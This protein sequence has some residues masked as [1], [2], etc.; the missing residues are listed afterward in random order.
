MTR[1]FRGIDFAN[2]QENR[3]TCFLMVEKGLVTPVLTEPTSVVEMSAVDCPFGTTVGFMELLMGSVRKVEPSGGYKAR[4]TEKWLRT[5]L[6]EF[7][8]NKFWRGLAHPRRPQHYVNKP[9]HVKSTLELQI[10]PALI[11][12]FYGDAGAT[13]DSQTL[14]QLREAR[15]GRGGIVEAHPRAFLYSAI[16]RIYREQPTNEVWKTV[17]GDVATYKDHQKVS[18]TAQRRRVY[19]F[20]QL[21]SSDWLWNDLHLSDAPELLFSTDHHFDAFLAALT[22]LA[23]ADGQTIGWSAAGLS[24]ENVKI[25][26]HILILSTPSETETGQQ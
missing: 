17:L 4:E 2:S 6:W 8:S 10:V 18:H 14:P 3:R 22:A 7:K 26:G 9:A 15:L 21:H 16:E 12:W 19:S 1:W 5:Y 25:E 24:E 11:S 23:H 20:L 13:S